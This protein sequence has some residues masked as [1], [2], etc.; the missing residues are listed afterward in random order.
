VALR[1]RSH[2]VTASLLLHR[3]S[4]SRSRPRTHPRS[5]PRCWR[6]RS[7]ALDLLRLSL[8][9]S[10][11]PASLTSAQGFISLLNED[12]PELQIYAL[13]KLND[14]VD[15]FWAEIG[16]DS[17]KRMYVRHL[18]TA[19]APSLVAFMCV[20]VCAVVS[21]GCSEILHEDPTFQ[22]RELA[23]LLAAKVCARRVRE[24]QSESI[25]T[26]I[27]MLS[28]DRQGLLPSRR[29]YHGHALC[30]GRGIQVPGRQEQRVR[31][32]LA[33]YVVPPPPP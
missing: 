26:H 2:R 9:T 18:R 19:L 30:A 22:E 25:A 5:L 24:S 23:A 29:L 15:E 33:P 10:R 28:C 31:R 14:V 21:R 13:R 32:Y 27:S 17:I 8:S 11:M 4:R 20:C 3:L 12:E 1:W 16:H 7:L 6:A